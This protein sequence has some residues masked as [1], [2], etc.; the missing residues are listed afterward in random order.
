MNYDID[1]AEVIDN[2][3]NPIRVYSQG[4]GFHGAIYTAPE[5]HFDLVFAYTKAFDT[6]F[7]YGV[8]IQKVLALGGGIYAW[9]RHALKEHNTLEMDVVEIDQ[10]TVDLAYDAFF[11]EEDSL[12]FSNR[13][14][15]I[16]TDA[17]S[18]LE[19]T[20]NNYDA[21]VGDVYETLYPAFDVLTLEAT[22]QICARLKQ[23]GIYICNF[24]NEPVLLRSYLATLHVLFPYVSVQEVEDNFLEESTTNIIVTA[25]KE[26]YFKSTPYVPSTILYDND[27][28]QIHSQYQKRLSEDY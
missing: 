27:I 15:T 18:Y 16:V 17:R 4:G 23:T 19:N 21:I 25:A 14:Q 1:I 9:P 20:E 24:P 5:K 6:V 13:L 7:T 26:P 28:E 2:D 10:E 3:G 12:S 11:L 22:K 8:P